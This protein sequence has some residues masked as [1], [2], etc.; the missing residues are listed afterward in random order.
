MTYAE[1]LKEPEWRALKGRLLQERGCRCE[2]CGDTDSRLEL[3]HGYYQRKLEP[4]Q[5]DR[6]T[7]WLLCPD[8]HDEFQ[9]RLEDIGKQ[10]ALIHPRYHFEALCAIKRLNRSIDAHEHKEGLAAG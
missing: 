1:K 6:D 2:G 3:H 5:Y 9:F 4:W 8:C 10:I 7:L